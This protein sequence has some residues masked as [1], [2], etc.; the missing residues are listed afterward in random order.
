VLC[1]K[2][3]MTGDSRVVPADDERE[4]IAAEM[5]LELMKRSVVQF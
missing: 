2:V 1:A 4:L 5:I 3:K